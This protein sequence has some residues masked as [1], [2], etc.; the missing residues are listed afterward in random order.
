MLKAGNI[1][2]IHI[3]PISIIITE[4]TVKLCILMMICL[5]PDLEVDT[6]KVK[7]ILS[8][9]IMGSIIYQKLSTLMASKS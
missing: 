4:G 3:Y 5:Q 6:G 7:E 9:V 2:I 8:R 1:S